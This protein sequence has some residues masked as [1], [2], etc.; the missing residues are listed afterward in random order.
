MTRPQAKK[1]DP[2]GCFASP[3]DPEAEQSVLGAILVRPQVLDQV[4]DILNPADFYREA[5]GRIYK[6][7]VDLY[8]K[9]EPIDYVTV[10]ALLKDR[11]QLESVGGAVFIVT[12][13]NEVGFA[14]NAPF[15]AQRVRDKAELRRLLDAAKEIAGAC[16]APVEN[17]PEF[18]DAAEARIYEVSH[19]Q[20][21][22]KIES[23]GELAKADYER[24][25]T[26]YYHGKEAH[27]LLTGF[28]DLDKLTG[29]LYPGDETILA[30][31]PSMGK[32]ALALNIAWN[33]GHTLGEPVAIFSLE[34]PK[35]QLIRRIVSS[36]ARID[37]NTLKR[38]QLSSND[39]AA[40][41]QIQAELEDAPIYLDDRRGLSA[42]ELRARCRRIK[43]RYGL[44]LVI[45]DYLQLMR[46][47]ARARSRDEAV[48]SNAYSIKE[49]AG[50][51]GV[52]IL[53]C[54][55]VN[56]EIE[57]EKRKKYR[58]SDLRE[59]GG[60]EQAADN[61]LFLYRNEEAT[62]AD[63]TIGKQR[64]GP[65]GSLQLAYSPAFTRFDSYASS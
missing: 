6:A 41:A 56:R 65:V 45:V 31:R 44:S 32:T 10:T 23:V 43:A 2:Q 3:A 1:S 40:R 59:S 47:P 57:K 17:V 11:G 64:N 35:D 16:L 37:G 60:V 38:C 63:L 12:L 15:Y 34:M 30:A 61:I 50:E 8:A 14:V 21:S 42:L 49:L 48:S 25:E 29:G 9:N 54:C 51:L 4:A 7:I 39:W 46:E 55:Q 13:S 36:V 26:L 28:Y 24:L 22:A 5:H 20:T 19:G 33:V 52:P 53:V 27:G 18:L 58:L 62:V